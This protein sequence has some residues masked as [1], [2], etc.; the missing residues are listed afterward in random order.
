MSEVQFYYN[1]NNYNIQCNK[2]EKIKEI[3]N[4]FK[5][6]IGQN[7]TQF[8]YIYN[9]N[10]ITNEELTFDQ[11]SSTYDKN[12]NKMAILVIEQT[13]SDRNSKQIPV[14]SQFI[15]KD[16]RVKDEEMKE[17]AEMTIMYAMQKYP[18]DDAQKSKFVRDKFID[19]YGH[20]WSV[21]FIKN[22]N[23]WITYYS[24][25]IEVLYN[26]YQ[27]SIGRTSIND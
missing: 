26:G 22:G 14:S 15:Y 18:D 20:V 10:I 19:K 2:Y 4:R 17:F 13:E 23:C 6:K 1:G 5:S 21:C 16:C 7:Q 27:V 24:Y 3:C 9:G 12:R 8:I 25:F 11:I